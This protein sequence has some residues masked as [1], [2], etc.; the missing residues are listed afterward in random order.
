MTAYSIFILISISFLIYISKKLTSHLFDQNFFWKLAFFT[1]GSSIIGAKI[2]H[3]LEN[4]TYYAINPETVFST[5]GFS[6]LGAISFGFITIFIL[7]TIYKT[8]F[9]HITD[10]L[11]L[12]TPIA[13]TIGR[14]G[15]ITN[16]ELMPF[17]AY[18]M[19]LNIINFTILLA[20]Y[21]LK[22]IDGLVT[23]LFFFNYGLIRIYIEFA[24][25]NYF[26]FL[27]I[28]S[29]VFLTYGLSKLVKIVFKL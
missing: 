15:N 27:T 22:K 28:I 19:G 6:V 14:V 16:N 3:V 12:V 5:Y 4:F 2:F 1:L 18:E 26:G 13:Q 29:I 17:S 11:L 23:A 20:A 24:K 7:S 25:G 9:L 8:K 10:R 21:K